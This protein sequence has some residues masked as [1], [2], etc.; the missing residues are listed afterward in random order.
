MNINQKVVC[1]NDDFPPIK[2][3]EDLSH[4]SSGIFNSAGN[5]PKL[6]EVI[7]IDDVLGD[8]LRFE[9]YDTVESFNW[10]IAD[11]FAPIDDE[12]VEKK[13]KL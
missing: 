12:K 13:I 4:P 3:Y 10:W 9:K 1:I 11:N 7:I 6:R 2:K 5:K 8:F